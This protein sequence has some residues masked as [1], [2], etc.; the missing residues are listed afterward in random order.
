MRRL[1]VTALSVALL[2][3]CS[4][5]KPQVAAKPADD[6]QAASGPNDVRCAGCV[7][8]GYGAACPAGC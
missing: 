4:T 6:P 5:G 8:M 3:A 2:A 1:V 7:F